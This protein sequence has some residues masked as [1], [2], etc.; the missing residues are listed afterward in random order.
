[1][2]FQ[3]WSIVLA[4]VLFLGLGEA[5]GAKPFC[6]DNKCTGQET[7]ESCPADCGAGGSCGDGT[8]DGS[9]S[10]ETC[11]ADCGSCPPPPPPA[12]CNNDGVCNLGEDCSSCPGDCDSK[13]SGKRSER[14]CCGDDAFDEARCGPYTG[15]DPPVCGDGTLADYGEECDDG[16]LINGDGCSDLCEIEISMPLTPTNQFN[17]GDSIGEGEA[18]N[19]SIGSSRHKTVWSTGYDGGDIVQ[20]LNERFEVA[21]PAF[22]YENDST[23]D[24]T[25]NQAVSGANMVDF[26]DQAQDVVN[27]AASTPTG[28]AGMVTILLGNNDVCAETLGDMLD[29]A[30]FEAQYRAG[31]DVLAQSPRTRFA[32][33]HVSSLP[34][35]Y[36]LWAA[37]RDDLYCRLLAWP[38]VPCQNLLDDPAD[39]CESSDSRKD[40]DNISPGDGDDCVRRKQ[41]HAEIRDVYNPILQDVLTEYRLNGALPNSEFVDVFDVRFKSS[42]VNDGDCFHPSEEGHSVLA[43]KNWCR[44]QWGAEDELCSP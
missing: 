18:A 26:A 39:D 41:F 28:E 23:R 5:R 44:S 3:H 37:K 11:S 35:I 22:Y 21:D 14:F 4:A 15:S 30:L 27:Q 10:C 32:N 16:N 43:E 12:S 13:T 38:F 42:Y 31:L 19:G 36:W 24:G 33:I 40:P 1:M 6:G 8:C 7:A 25:F 2:T 34:A 9:E 29:P 17:I 20:S